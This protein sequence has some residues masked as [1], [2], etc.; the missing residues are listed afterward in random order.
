MRQLKPLLKI[1]ASGMV[2]LL[3]ACGQQPTTDPISK[4]DAQKLK[5]SLTQSNKYLVAAIASPSGVVTTNTAGGLSL[6]SPVANLILASGLQP[7]SINCTASETPP[8]AQQQ[9]LDNDKIP[10]QATYRVDC[11]VGDTRLRGGIVLRDKDD[12]NPTSGYTVDTDQYQLTFNTGK[13]NESGVKLDLDLDVT[14][15]NPNYAVRYNFNFEIYGSDGLY[16]TT[17]TYTATYVPDNAQTPFAAGTFNYEGSLDFRT[18][19]KLYRLT[20]KTTDLKFSNACKETFVGGSWNLEDTHG[21]KL[22]VVYNACNNV[23]VTY[24][25]EAL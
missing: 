24:N 18:P 16:G 15:N 13:S 2:G 17:Y 12:N 25:G 1:L 6:P 23:T 3:A 9:D 8:K 21:N 11:T 19:T 10:L 20:G 7:Q 4:A 14:W 5:D 22:F